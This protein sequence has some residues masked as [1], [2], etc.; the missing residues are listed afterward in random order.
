MKGQGSRTCRL[1]DYLHDA[2][3]KGLWDNQP[4]IH[5]QIEIIGPDPAHPERISIRRS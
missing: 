4:E 5:R 3:F 1:P 2:A